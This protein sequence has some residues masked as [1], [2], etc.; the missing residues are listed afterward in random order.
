VQHPP[1]VRASGAQPRRARRSR[2]CPD[3]EDPTRRSLAA[4][5]RLPTAARPRCHSMAIGH[6]STPSA[7]TTE[8][9]SH[10]EG[11]SVRTA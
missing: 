11:R 3:V 1:R 5:Q 10:E 2:G 6:S 7:T 9:P 4:G 8:V